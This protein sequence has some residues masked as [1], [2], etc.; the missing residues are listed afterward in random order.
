MKTG[1]GGMAKMNDGRLWS[2][3]R[4]E[5][6]DMKINTKYDD[7]IT[8]FCNRNNKKNENDEENK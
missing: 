3:N 4:A 6:G 1:L 2:E 8:L 5:S 7:P